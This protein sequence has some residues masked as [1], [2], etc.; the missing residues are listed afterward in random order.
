MCGH[1]LTK[2]PFTW[3]KVDETVHTA[4]LKIQVASA[5]L[6]LLYHR[7]DIF[8]LVEPDMPNAIQQFFGDTDDGILFTHASR[9]FIEF[10]R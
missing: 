8:G 4:L 7:N 9:K 1:S 6:F 10:E 2:I 3:D 5:N